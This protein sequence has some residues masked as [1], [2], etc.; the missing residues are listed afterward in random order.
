VGATSGDAGPAT[1]AQIRQPFGLAFDAAGNLYFADNAANLVRKIAPDGTIST[2]AG[3][4]AASETG[5]GGPATQANLNGPYNVSVDS[6]GNVYIADYFGNALRVVTTDGIIH[7]VA[8]GVPFDLLTYRALDFGAFGGDGG[9]A[10]GAHYSGI[11]AAAF[12][13]SR[14]IYVLDQDNERIRVLTPNQ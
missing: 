4:G 11:L 9:P 5:D 2:F 13:G 1:A 6:A 14:N 10:I 8:S 3:K 7:T 12:D